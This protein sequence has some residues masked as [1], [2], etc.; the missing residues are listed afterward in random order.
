MSSSRAKIPGSFP[1]VRATFVAPTF[2]LPCSRTSFPATILTMRKLKGIEPI[3]YASAVSA[4]GSMRGVLYGQP[5]GTDA[6][7]GTDVP[8]TA[9]AGLHPFERVLEIGDQVFDVFDPDADAHQAGGDAE[10]L[11]HL[12]RNRTVGHALGVGDQGLHAAEGLGQGAESDAIEELLGVV[13]RAEVEGD[14]R[15]EAVHLPLR[16]LVLR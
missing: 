10:A 5:H 11:A 2:W 3:R 1:A 12:W 8:M 13:E 16:Q 6:T 4:A 9:D 15:T 14:H 7:Y